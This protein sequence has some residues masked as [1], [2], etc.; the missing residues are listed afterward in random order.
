[1][2][3]NIQNMVGHAS[4]DKTNGKV[5]IVYEHIPDLWW[6]SQGDSESKRM[7]K[8]SRLAIQL[9]LDWFT[10]E[11]FHDSVF[12]FQDLVMVGPFDPEATS[13]PTLCRV[14]DLKGLSTEELFK[15]I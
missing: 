4:N 10:L 13:T 11:Y 7:F 2:E 8:H 1:M 3:K 12:A 15:W 6:I 9:G 14:G 5:H